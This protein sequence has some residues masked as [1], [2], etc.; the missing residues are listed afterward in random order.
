MTNILEKVE[1]SLANFVPRSQREF[2]VFQ[3]ARRFKEQDRLAFYLNST[4]EFP[5]RM[6][7][8]AARL[9]AQRANEEGRAQSTEFFRLLERFKAQQEASP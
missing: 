1:A 7:L 5:K 8:E 3:V 6:I 2:V 4:R 9:A